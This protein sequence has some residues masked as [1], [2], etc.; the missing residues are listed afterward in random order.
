VKFLF[1]KSKISQTV[2]PMS[3]DLLFEV[4]DAIKD[5]PEIELIEVQGHADVVGPEAYNVILSRERANAVKD[6]LTKRGIESKKLVAR[7][8]GSKMPQASSESEDGRKENRRVQFLIIK[9][10]LKKP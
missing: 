5:H 8:Y 1:G 10:V 4:R 7:G 6:W 2:D 3:D 9:I